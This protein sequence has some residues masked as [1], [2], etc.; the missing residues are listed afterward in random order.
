MLGTLLERLV[1]AVTADTAGFSAGMTD[2]LASV[3]AATGGMGRGITS[4]GNQISSFGVKM[5]A[6]LTVPVAAAGYSL[7]KSA[8]DFEAAMIATGAAAQATGKDFDDLSDLARDLGSAWDYGAVTVA[9]AMEEFIKNGRSTKDALDGAMKSVVVMSRAAG[10]DLKVGVDVATDAMNNFEI[11][12]SDMAHVSDQVVGTLIASKFGLDDYRL[13]MGMAGG[14][15]H[16]LG[17]NFEDFNAVISA[18]ASS[19]TSGSDAGTSFK[20]MLIRMIPQSKEAAAAMK[21]YGLEFFD[22]TGKMK[23]MTDIADMLKRQ[24]GGLSDEAKNQVLKDIFGVDAMRMASALIRAGGDD[25][26]AMKAAIADVSAEDIASKKLEGL[27]G[28]LRDLKAAWMELGIAF[29]ESGALEAITNLVRGLTDF[30]KWLGQLPAPVLA[31]GGAL[32]GLVAVVGPLTVMIGQVV[33]A[34]GALVTAFEVGGL[35]AAGGALAGIGAALGAILAP[36]LA[37]AA[38]AAAVAA[39]VAA[40]YMVFKD[41]LQPVIDRLVAAFNKDVVPVFRTAFAAMSDMVSAFGE[42]FSSIAQGPVGQAVSYIVKILGELLGVVGETLGTGIMWVLRALGEA[43]TGI[44]GTIAELVR[45]LAA[46]LRGDGV[47]AWEHFKT[48]GSK[49]ME[50]LLRSMTSLLGSALGMVEQLYNGVKK[51]LVDRMNDAIDAVVDKLVSL[52][53]AFFELYDKVIGHSYVPDMVEGIEKYFARLDAGMVKPALAATEKTA[54]AFEDMRNNV[55]AVMSDLL[56]PTESAQREFDR[57]MKVL[58]DAVLAGPDK[59]GITQAEYDQARER[60]IRQFNKETVTP[61]TVDQNPGQLNTVDDIVKQLQ[62]RSAEVREWFA[63]TFADGVKAI[64]TGHGGDFLRSWFEK[65]LDEALNN[66]GKWIF[67][68]IR[69]NEGWGGTVSAI[70]NVFGGFRAAGGPVKSGVGYVVG[71]KGPELFVP[72]SSGGIVPNGA[73]G[74]GMTVIHVH[75]NDAVLTSTVREWIGQGMAAAEQSA[76]GRSVSTARSVV[77]SEMVRRGRRSFV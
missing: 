36:A 66:L 1:V 24:L 55:A 71:E 52:G 64:A 16:N 77:P 72:N 11:S 37:F 2:A 7:L 44:F 22:A 17:V 73:G 74:R 21:K 19:F 75:A 18:T 27:A 39:A 38:A 6:A 33:S 25:I 40:I 26:R 42:L 15:A 48:A 28:R 56:T 62:A 69:G 13:A 34:V 35:F 20:V 59:G 43:F 5:S 67:D 10:E 54:K 23:S 3:R 63:S 9:S 29:G 41:Q 4:L 61:A 46:L 47:A 32:L 65:S 49:L 8:S 50:G 30:V 12:A 51:W 45:G 76:V 68:K 14:A 70:A 31:V 53:V 58:N 57:K 60:Q